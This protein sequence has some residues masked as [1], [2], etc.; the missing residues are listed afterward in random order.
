MARIAEKSSKKS[1]S[2]KAAKV[3]YHRRPE[4]MKLEL[5][6]LGLRKNS[7]AKKMSFT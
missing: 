1:K 2:N 7:L 6:Q 3:S 4:D 5:W